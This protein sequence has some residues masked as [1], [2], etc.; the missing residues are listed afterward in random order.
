MNIQ[1]FRVWGSRG[2]WGKRC[3]VEPHPTH[4]LRRLCSATPSYFRG[5]RTERLETSSSE[6]LRPEGPETLNWPISP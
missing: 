3:K 6:F 5:R 2:V 4:M 1:G